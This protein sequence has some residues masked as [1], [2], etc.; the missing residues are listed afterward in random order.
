MRLTPRVQR[1]RGRRSAENYARLRQVKTVY[2]P[3][4]LFRL[5]ANLPPA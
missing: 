3:T 4:N 2:D 1:G 5:N